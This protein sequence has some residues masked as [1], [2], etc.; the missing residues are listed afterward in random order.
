MRSID[1]TGV[2]GKAGG[3]AKSLLILLRAFVASFITSDKEVFTSSMEKIECKN[4]L[5]KPVTWVL[6]LVLRWV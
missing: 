5:C 3:D 4:R 6:K 2:R 1:A